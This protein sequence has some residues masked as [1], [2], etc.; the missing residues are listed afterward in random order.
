MDVRTSI[1][2]NKGPAFYDI[3]SPTNKVPPIDHSSTHRSTADPESRPFP[4]P[5]EPL[6]HEIEPIGCLVFAQSPSE[7]SV[8]SIS[9]AGDSEYSTSQTIYLTEEEEPSCPVL[10]F[11]SPPK[12]VRHMRRTSLMLRPVSSGGPAPQV[13]SP[14]PVKVR[15]PA[16]RGVPLQ[17]P[18]RLPPTPSPRRRSRRS[19]RQPQLL[20]GSTQNVSEPGS[21]T[22]LTP[23][24]GLV[25]LQVRTQRAD[26]N[27]PQG[28]RR[29][30]KHVRGLNSRVLLPPPHTPVRPFRPLPPLPTTAPLNACLDTL[31]GADIG[32]EFE[33]LTELISSAS[34]DTSGLLST[35]HSTGLDI[36]TAWSQKEFYP[37]SD[38][39][40]SCAPTRQDKYAS[41]FLN[42][43]PSVL[44]PISPEPLNTIR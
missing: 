12:P 40:W 13:L 31:G 23:E 20:Y 25:Q 10:Q 33:S 2:S 28:Y 29:S 8:H 44:S 38:Y 18:R 9:S 6:N 43:D 19:I 22:S 32:S 15:F 21:P 36:V 26:K 11:V 17:A 16:R 35:P 41:T 39:P 24:E 4:P 27:T 42:L 7:C 1:F 3:L 37:A 5:K 34:S 30:F 14:P